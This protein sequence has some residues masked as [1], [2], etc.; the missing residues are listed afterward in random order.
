MAEAPAE[1]LPPE[2][3][4]QGE[5]VEAH[6]PPRGVVD[7]PRPPREY[8]GLKETQI[9]LTLDR[10]HERLLF[11][12]T[13]IAK[14]PG[15]L[16]VITAAHCFLAEDVGRTVLITQG[17]ET[18]RGRVD[19]V[20]RNP[21][22][23]AQPG[24]SPGVGMI[25]GHD[26]AFALLRADL[27]AADR[28]GAFGAIRPAA[29]A[30]RPFLPP[31]GGSMVV[32]VRDHTGREYAIRAGNNLNPRLLAWGEC[33]RPDPAIPE[34]ESSSRTDRRGRPSRPW[35]ASCRPMTKTT[36]AGP[37]PSSARKT[38]GS[39]RPSRRTYVCA[40]LGNSH[41]SVTAELAESHLTD[42]FRD[43]PETGRARSR[44]PQCRAHHR[45]CG[46]RPRAAHKA[47]RS[48]RAI[49]RFGGGSVSGPQVYHDQ[50]PRGPGVPATRGTGSRAASRRPEGRQARTGPPPGVV[51]RSVRPRC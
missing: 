24:Q 35:W 22:F 36:T 8:P 4:P 48:S 28:A 27:P 11:Q 6:E 18:W 15:E 19:A 29:V 45:S 46:G 13:V 34:A 16:R 14:D 33:S 39:G 47:A 44:F 43:C 50:S 38:R 17:A 25:S 40:F 49:N 9:V 42:L 23:P 20:V 51:G 10:D 41:C 21:A 5:K 26:A 1:F 2:P 7:G 37:R 12:A 3:P 30:S 31:S 32:Y